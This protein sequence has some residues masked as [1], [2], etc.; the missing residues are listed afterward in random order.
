MSIWRQLSRG[1]R[2]LTN[3]R[4]ADQD[5]TDEVESYLEQAAQALEAS[6]VSPNEARRVVRLHLGNA[7]TVREQVRSYGWENVIS[8]RVSDVRYAARRLRHTPGFTTVCVLTLAIGIGANSA[9]FSVINGILLKPLP[10]HNPDELIDLNHTAPGVNFPDADPAPF[11]YFTYREQGRSFRSIG[12]Y[13]SQSSSVTGLTE[14]EQAQCLGVTSEI[15]PMLG[16]E[17]ELG[18]WFSRKDDAPGSPPTM[19]L[20]QGWWQKRFGGDRSVIGRRI[21]VDGIS[22]EVIGVMPAQF[23]FLDRDPAFLVPLQFDRNKAFLG[24]FNYP[25]IARLKPGVTIEQASADIARMIPIALHSFPPQPGLTVKV[26]EDV[27]LAPKLKYLKQAL[28]GDVARTLWVLMGTLSVVLLIACANIANLFLVRAEGRRNELAVRAALGARWGDIAR[29]LLTESMLLGVLG[30]VLGLAL[31]CGA[32]RLLVAIAPANLP[33]LSEISINPVVVLFTFGTALITGLVFGII[34]ILKYGGPKVATGLRAGSRTSSQTKR[35]YRV[36]SALV[37]VQ[38]ALALVLLIGSGLMIR[39]FRMLHRVDPGFDPKDA[40]TVR[41]NIPETTVKD[42]EAVTRLEQSILE[43]IRAIPGVSSAGITTVIPTVAASGSRQVYARDKMYRSVPPLRRLKFISPGLLASMGNNLIVG[44]EFTWADTY[45]RHPVAMVSENLARELWG[46]PRL[47]IGKQINANPKDPWREV[48]GV[49]KDEREDGVQLEAPAVAY[50]PLLMDEFDGQKFGAVR[51]VS[52]VAR[53]KRAGSRR[54]F[55]DVQQAVWS[56]NGTL[57]L[58]DVRTLEEIYDKSLARTSFTLV[59]LA[60]AGAMALLIGVVGIYA[61]ISY[62]V[63]Q[64]RRE[65]GIRVA[66]GAGRRELARLFVAHGFVLALTG[67]GCG[68]AGAV[69]LTRFLVSLLFGVNALDPLTYAAVSFGLLVAAV[70]ATYIPTLRAM[71]VDPVDAL[72]AE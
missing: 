31:A 32:I 65:V 72:R 37:V 41:I 39:T 36:N 68:L 42:P 69:V 3:R 15:L 66:L 61:V 24:Q 60:I 52:Y 11:L 22:R 10:Y 51:T 6:G 8:A 9:I 44:R 23:R 46:D 28:V 4:V 45:Q 35:Q 49:V 2:A 67:V 30:G 55:L 58:G 16:V 48:I 20:M 64:R 54:L 71:R 59:M 70:A 53:S 40:L 13:R 34:P 25:G 1:L 18:R 19:V 14:P 27:R 5:I 50:Y 12:L 56:G 57:P 21:I 7:T 29:A 38:V 17:P 33:R 63:S 43:N 26:F 47:A 62:S